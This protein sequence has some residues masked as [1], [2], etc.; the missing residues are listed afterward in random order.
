MDDALAGQSG[1]DFLNVCNCG[2]EWYE[3][4]ISKCDV[5]RVGSRH[6]S[7]LV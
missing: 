6:V 2:H 7:G 5:K 3:V 1:V 4:N